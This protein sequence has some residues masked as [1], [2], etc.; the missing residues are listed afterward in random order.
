MFTGRE[1][2]LWNQ[3][4]GRAVDDGT[5]HDES[6][7]IARSPFLGLPLDFQ[8]A[9]EKRFVV[10]QYDGY[11]LGYPLG[12]LASST[13]ELKQ[14][15]HEACQELRSQGLQGVWIYHDGEALD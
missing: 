13:F 3:V 2:T 9:S 7:V 15:A 8:E 4:R 12:D 14:Q 11:V 6:R 1:V 10:Y 5:P